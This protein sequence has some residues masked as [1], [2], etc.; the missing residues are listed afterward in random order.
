MISIDHH[1][2]KEANLHSKSLRSAEAE[3]FLQLAPSTQ[4]VVLAR[5]PWLN[6]H[7]LGQHHRADAFQS[8]RSV[9][10]RMG[11]NKGPM[12]RRISTVV[13]FSPVTR[14]KSG[15]ILGQVCDH[16]DRKRSVDASVHTWS[17]PNLAAIETAPGP[18]FY[19][20]AWGSSA[21][22]L[23]P[24]PSTAPS[25]PSPP[26][27]TLASSHNTILQARQGQA[28]RRDRV[29][30]EATPRAAP[31]RAIPPAAPL[32]HQRTSRA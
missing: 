21:K 13:L 31:D 24:I 30:V 16:T 18:S 29:L 28:R 6:P 15:P 26:A 4:Q 5:N 27:Q 11:R 7:F 25:A 20:L 12:R 10:I 2:S 19:P 23:L 17:R 3:R 32:R 1:A 22:S 14:R 8:D 9:S